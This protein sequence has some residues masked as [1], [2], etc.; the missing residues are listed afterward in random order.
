[1]IIDLARQAGV[2]FENMN[3]D[4]L[5]KAGRVW[6]GLT[7]HYGQTNRTAEQSLDIYNRNLNQ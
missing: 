3:V 6:A 7:P 4:Q 5:R 1:M 2:D